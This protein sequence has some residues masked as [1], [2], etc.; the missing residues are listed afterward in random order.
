MKVALQEGVGGGGRWGRTRGGGGGRLATG[1]GGQKAIHGVVQGVQIP[2][3][4]M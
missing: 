1:G 2:T 3:C 4:Q